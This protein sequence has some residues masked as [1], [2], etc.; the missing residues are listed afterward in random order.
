MAGSFKIGNLVDAYFCIFALYMLESLPRHLDFF[1][2]LLFLVG[3][4]NN[5]VEQMGRSKL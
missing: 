5:L 3:L 2:L 1:S 4:L